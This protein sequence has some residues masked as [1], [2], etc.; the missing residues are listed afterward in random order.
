M[1]ER[2]EVYLEEYLSTHNSELRRHPRYRSDMNF[3]Q[4]TSDGDLVM[5]TRDKVLH[6]DDKLVFTEVADAVS[7]KIKLIV[8]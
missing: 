4:V 7:M 8:L 1:S 2:K 6:S 3:T 5:S